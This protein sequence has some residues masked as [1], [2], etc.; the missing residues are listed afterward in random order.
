MGPEASPRPSVSPTPMLP[1]GV[2]N[3]KARLSIGSD[4]SPFSLASTATNTPSPAM[5]RNLEEPDTEMEV[6][7]SSPQQLAPSL[8]SSLQNTSIFG[9]IS[10]GEDTNLDKTPIFTNPIDSSLEDEREEES[11]RQKTSE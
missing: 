5:M 6:A 4:M 2:G 3:V 10:S 11:K 8:N 7:P 1:S 9:L